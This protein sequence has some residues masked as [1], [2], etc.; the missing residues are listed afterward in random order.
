MPSNMKVTLFNN[1]SDEKVVGKN[2]AK[3][4]E[5]TE[6]RW[7]ENTDILN[8]TITFHKFTDEDGHQVW[9]QFN[10]IMLEWSG[11]PTRYYFVDKMSMNKGG[12]IEIVCRVD[13]RQT[14]R[15]Q[16]R[17]KKFLVAR[18]ENVHNKYIADN[19]IVLTDARQIETVTF[20]QQVGTT[21]G[22]IILTVS[23]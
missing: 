8:P 1:T 12:I 18:Q 4:A 23:G 10:Y 17:T 7:K 20:A 16:M 11:L 3:V 9:K 22:S 6:V 13:V 14:W 21:G 2:L 19:R 15:K 5:L